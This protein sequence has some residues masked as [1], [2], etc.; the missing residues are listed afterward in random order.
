M[1]VKKKN[2]E[3]SSMSFDALPVGAT[4]RWA[5]NADKLVLMKVKHILQPYDSLVV[6]L[7]DGCLL[8]VADCSVRVVLVQGAFV[9]GEE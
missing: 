9:E 8:P 6:V 7:T 4:F 2:D 5:D 3:Q 1:R